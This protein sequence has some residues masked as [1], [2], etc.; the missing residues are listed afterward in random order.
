MKLYELE[1]LLRFMRD[2]GADNLT[3]VKLRI[4]CENEY[5]LSSV[6]VIKDED[7][8]LIIVLDN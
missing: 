4:W 1:K 6:S 3:E 5:D 7:D 2:D 8:R